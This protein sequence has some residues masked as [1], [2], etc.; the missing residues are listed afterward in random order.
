M[1]YRSATLDELDARRPGEC[2]GMQRGRRRVGNVNGT[3]EQRRE[4]EAVRK[5]G[6][7]GAGLSF[8]LHPTRR[9]AAAQEAG[10]GEWL[11][12]MDE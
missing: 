10:T 7:R 8:L 5:L 12:E 4:N 2:N 11:G 6:G 3:R 1:L 9:R